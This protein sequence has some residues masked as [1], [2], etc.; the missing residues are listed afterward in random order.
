M[1]VCMYLEGIG[2]SCMH[3]MH[4]VHDP[5]MVQYGW[6]MH[7]RMPKCPKRVSSVLFCSAICL[8]N[9]KMC[10]KRRFLVAR[11]KFGVT[12]NDFSV[13]DL[14]GAFSYYMKEWDASPVDHWN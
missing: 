11:A 12:E 5:V 6:C 4:H 13:N 9:A 10:E 2:Y 3:R 1:H 8:Q 7:G 14:F